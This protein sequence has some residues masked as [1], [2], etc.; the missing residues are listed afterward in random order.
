MKNGGN[1]NEDK[2]AMYPTLRKKAKRF[3]HV[4]IGKVGNLVMENCEGNPYVITEIDEPNQRH[5]TE[6]APLFSDSTATWNQTFTL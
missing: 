5:K 2:Q 3:L 1:E 4:C 6:S